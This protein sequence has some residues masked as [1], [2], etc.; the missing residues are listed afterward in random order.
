[1]S[2]A[3]PVFFWGLISLIPLIAIY[4][5]KVRPTRKP[6]TAW[7]LWEKIFQERRASAL[8]KRFRDV[9]SLLLLAV[10]FA[11]VVTATTRPFWKGDD[12]MD[13]VLLI[14]NS[15]SMNAKDGGQTRLDWAKRVAGDIVRDL[16]G[17]QR[18]SIATVAQNVFFQSNV[19][20]NPKELQDAIDRIEP[21]SMPLALAALGPFANRD[22]APTADVGAPRSDPS[23]T[24]P[25]VPVAINGTSDNPGKTHRVIL[26]SDGCLGGPLPEAIELMKVG[27]SQRQNVGLVACDLQRLPT[28]NGRVGVFFQIASTF[29]Q[30]LHLD[31]SVC[32]ET[33]DHL[34][35]LIPLTIQPGVN[36]AE[37]FQ[38]DNA[39]EGRWL[40]QLDIA[41][42]LA[43]DNT[44]FV[45]LPPR[46]PIE[47]SVAAENRFFYDQSVMAFSQSG[48]LLQLVD[49]VSAQLV[50][51][52]G[53]VPLDGL[54]PD[55][56]LLLFQPQGESPWWSEVGED[57]APA[58]PRILDESHP[59]IRHLDAAAIPY[60]G[61]RRIK[62]PAGSE[63]WVVAEDGSPLIYRASHAGR[64]AVV[65][66]LDPFAAEFFLSPWFPVLVYSTATHLAGRTEPIRSTYATGQAVPIQG[67]QEGESADWTFPNGGVADTS[68]A[69]SQP[70]GEIGFHAIKNSAG[71][72]TIGCSLVSETETMLDNSEVQETAQAISRG[73]SPTAL[74]TLLAI[75]VVVAESI[76]YQR[77]M[78]G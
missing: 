33:P 34:V 67:F 15:A 73:W 40:I 10:V 50:L 64:N 31:L 5:L 53:N 69:Y 45:V 29:D 9:F 63:V 66:N 18:C 14:D 17:T 23:G 30:P 26:I 20:D 7:F 25:S 61:A 62:P 77:R 3:N 2:F 54:A 22:N 71:P 78:V 57:F 49:V 37:V 21:S 11:A 39:A 4:F 65:V 76:L 35:K 12:R 41:D 68:E 55:T 51:G 27:Q 38:I 44:A 46:V 59:V 47:V 13:L 56:D 6:A 74:L 28:S 19:S 58:I 43:D 8:F 36:R 42:S 16:N 52:Q 75:V 32:H 70:L 48:N 24:D 60:V 1:M 72:W